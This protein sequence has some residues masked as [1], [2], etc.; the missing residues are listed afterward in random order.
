[1]KKII[2]IC[3]LSLS[4][5]SFSQTAIQTFNFDGNLSNQDNSISFT[6]ASSPNTTTFTT[7]RKGVANKAYS[8]P[9][10]QSLQAA[11]ANLP[12]GNTARSISFW[13]SFGNRTTQPHYLW[14]YGTSTANNAF[15]LSQ[16]PNNII[17]YGWANDHV[18]ALSFAVGVWY[19]YV[20]TY[21]G[22]T[23]KIYRD[24]L[25]ISQSAK[26]WNTVGSTFRIGA[27]SSSSVYFTGS[28]DELKIYNVALTASQVSTLYNPPSLPVI[29][30]IIKSVGTSFSEYNIGY[31]LTPND[32]NATT[33]IKYGTSKTN[34]N[35]TSAGS[36]VGSN[37]INISE[38]LSG[39]A[40]NTKYYFRVDA[41]NSVGSVSSVIDSFTTNVAPTAPTVNLGTA[42]VSGSTATINYTAQ[43]NFANSSVRVIYGISKTNLNMQSAYITVYGSTNNA[44]TNCTSTLTS[45]TTNT[46]YFY[47]IEGMNTSGTSTSGLD[48][49]S[50]G[51]LLKDGL[52]AYYNFQNNYLSNNGMHSLQSATS[53]S[54]APAFVSGK[55]G[56]AVTL[57]GTQALVDTTITSMFNSANT[58]QEFSICFWE[59]RNY[60]ALYATSY[61]FFGSQYFRYNTNID[62]YEYGINTNG[63]GVWN[64][65]G[66]NSVYNNIPNVWHHIAIVLIK[67]GIGKK[68]RFYRNG[69]LEQELSIAATATMYKFNKVF[70]VGSGTNA[71]G[72]INNIKNF[73][74]SIDEM[75]IYNRGLTL[76]EVTTVMNNAAGVLPTK[77]TNF[78]VTSKNNSNQLNWTSENKINIAQFNVEYSTNA[79]E[80]ETIGVVAAG[81][82]EY[83]Y[84]HQY[85]S[86]N[87]IQYYRLKVIDKDGKFTYSQIVKV[88]KATKIFDAEVYPTLVSDIV[89]LSISSKTKVD[90]T[91]SLLDLNGKC[92]TQ[93]N[94]NIHEGVNSNTF[95]LSHLTKGIYILKMNAGGEQV[96]QKIVKQ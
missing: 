75:Y 87:D 45:L 46:K 31:N 88:K 4:Y 89:T 86:Q 51:D 41:V 36:Y 78:T 17:N 39:L 50:I 1:M 80:F 53:N 47:K 27:T 96:V 12:V 29:T 57:D 54:T 13:V 76:A 55:Y 44:V 26:N 30:N 69:V 84:T 7:D 64:A 79:K 74:G 18:A 6:I 61:E 85:N 11:I 66:A 56:Q 59:K 28:I 62:K 34:L 92:I 49:F 38:V 3:F 71:N 67:D 23:S 94:I 40:G 32:A 5:L 93:K 42:T 90:V 68:L 14:S 52:L 95:N 91:I 22:T 63:S 73:A 77:I 65:I 10:G 82:K 21:D 72:T 8:V 9:L 33:D 35:L 48:S 2:T 19:H 58:D 15:G 70:S 20:V 81:K 16:E 24:G 60:L 37:A 43:A 25:L 83:N